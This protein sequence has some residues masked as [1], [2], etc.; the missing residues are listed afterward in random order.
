MNWQSVLKELRETLYW[1]RLIKRAE[2]LSDGIQNLENVF[3]ETN[4]LS[5]IIAKSIITA[6]QK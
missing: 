6:K 1:L 4:E 2:I 5:K 3:E